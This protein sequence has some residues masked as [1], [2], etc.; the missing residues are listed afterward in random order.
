[1]AS[2]CAAQAGSIPNHGK[3]YMQSGDGSVHEYDYENLAK[4]QG[5]ER[6]PRIIVEPDGSLSLAQD[7]DFV[8]KIPSNQ[9][10]LK[11]RLGV[12]HPESPQRNTISPRE[13]T[14]PETD[15]D[16]E[17][18]AKNKRTAELATSCEVKFKRAWSGFG[19]NSERAATIATGAP[20][21]LK[22]FDGNKIA[23]RFLGKQGD[24]L[25]FFDPSSERILF[26]KEANAKILNA[27]ANQLQK[28]V[29]FEK[30]VGPTCA[31]NQMVN[32]VKTLS[33]LNGLNSP[34]LKKMIDSSP[35]DFYNFVYK[36]VSPE[37]VQEMKSQ[38]VEGA[39]GWRRTL[40]AVVG[41]GYLQDKLKKQILEVA[42][43]EYKEHPSPNEVMGHLSQ[44]YPALIDTGVKIQKREIENLATKTTLP[45]DAL[46][47]AG[48]NDS[49]GRHSVVAVGIV[50]NW[51]WSD[52]VLVLDS[53]TGEINLWNLNDVMKKGSITLV[54]PSTRP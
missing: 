34:S 46:Q 25:Y 54:R 42:G 20:V 3:F 21:D 24:F 43:I 48:A 31:V 37:A 30:Q 41:T 35:S 38:S 26:V 51:L 23:G 22:L 2:F 5:T 44:G 16:D 27:N 4:N 10:E 17:S 12:L 29:E 15:L 13:T 32:C 49:I 50:H 7:E 47:P 18:L 52:K 45:H 19:I 53:S 28:I 6:Y 1:L 8:H 39:T 11:K 40:K 36:L 14:F 9:E 33:K